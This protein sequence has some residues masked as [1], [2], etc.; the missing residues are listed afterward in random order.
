M[1]IATS[2]NS[3]ALTEDD[4]KLDA[5]SSDDQQDQGKYSE[6]LKPLS[7]LRASPVGQGLSVDSFKL[8]NLKQSLQQMVAQPAVKKTLPALIIFFIL[9]LL[10]S[11]I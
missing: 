7:A 10:D 8:N 2:P 1:A 11:F 5:S 4:K 3:N 6:N 9:F